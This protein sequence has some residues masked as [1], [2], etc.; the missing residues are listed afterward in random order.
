MA[1][2]TIS[3]VTLISALAL[4]LFLIHFFDDMKRGE[5]ESQFGSFSVGLITYGIVWVTWLL[6]L[7]LMHLD[8]L[9]V[10]LGLVLVMSAL[11]AFPTLMMHVLGI[12]KYSFV[13]IMESSGLIFA[14]IA[15]L[16]SL[17]SFVVFVLSI[18]ALI[19]VMREG[20]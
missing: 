15:S 16:L 11:T 3:Y 14:I 4:L 9:K 8:R 5:I 19:N 2:N 20:G 7:F 13:E 12:G 1:D 17:I 6:S 10:G 18:I